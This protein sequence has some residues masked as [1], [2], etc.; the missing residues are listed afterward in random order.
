MGLYLQKYLEV[1]LLSVDMFLCSSVIKYLDF[2]YRKPGV[3]VHATVVDGCYNQ[4]VSFFTC[5]CLIT[6]MS[7][8]QDINMQQTSS[9]WNIEDMIRIKINCATYVNVREVGKV[10]SNECN[11]G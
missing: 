4:W 6:G 11:R 1:K 9:L 8:L 10:S 2:Q 3:R 5:Y 7:K